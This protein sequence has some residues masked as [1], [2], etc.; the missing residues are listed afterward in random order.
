MAW[1][2]YVVWLAW[3]VW[4]MWGALSGGGGKGRWLDWCLSDVKAKSVKVY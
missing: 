4:V 2:A 1:V 3:V